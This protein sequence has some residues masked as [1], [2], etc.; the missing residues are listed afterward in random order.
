MNLSIILPTRN[1]ELL[2]GRTLSD[3]TAFLKNRKIVDYEVLVVINGTQDNT[4]EIVKKDINQNKRIKIL[5]SEPGVGKALRV[6]LESAKGNYI[7]VFDVDFYDLLMIDFIKVDLLDKDFIIGSKMT[8]WAQ[9]KRP[10]ARRIVSWAFNF[11]L[12]VL[13]KFKGSDTHGTRI[14]RRKVV[15]TVLPKCKTDSGIFDAEFLLRAQYAGFKFADFPVS[16]KEKRPPRFIRRVWQTP[17]DILGLYL[18]LK[19]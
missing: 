1:E 13:L 4:E 10:I 16:V 17:K 3:I 9:D 15:E 19:E 6:G 7:A 14:F 2:I 12:K 18:S 8:S 11:F 5:R